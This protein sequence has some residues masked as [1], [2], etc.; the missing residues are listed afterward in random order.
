M[1][2]DESSRELVDRFFDGPADDEDKELVARLLFEIV[3]GTWSDHVRWEQDAARADQVIIEPRPEFVVV[4]RF[5]PRPATV[6]RRHLH[7]PARPALTGR[8]CPAR[9]SPRP[10]GAPADAPTPGKS[11]GPIGGTGA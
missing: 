5:Y 2:L 1:R 3:D 4:A 10:R 7:R 6:V 9:T 11:T 8:P